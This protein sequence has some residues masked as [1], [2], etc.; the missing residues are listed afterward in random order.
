[1]KTVSFIVLFFA[2]L[3]NAAV[4]AQSNS[5]ATNCAQETSIAKQAQ[6][7]GD[8]AK[9]NL[10]LDPR[11]EAWTVD[12]LSYL[13]R[14]LSHL[15]NGDRV[16]AMVELNEAIK[17][18][19]QIAEAYFTRGSIYAE[20]KDYDRALQDFDQAI[21]LN[22][23][24]TEAFHQRALAHRGKL[25]FS[26]ALKDLNTA[27]GMEPFNPSLLRERGEAHLA[28]GDYDRAVD[29]YQDAMSIDRSSIDPYSM[30]NLLFFQGRFSQ[31]AQT[32]QQ[33]LKIKPENPYAMLWRYLAFAKANGV[34]AAARELADHSTR[35]NDKRWPTAAIDYYLGKIDE[36]ALRG[37]A[38]SSEALKNSEQI[39]Q[40]NFFAGEAK[41]LKGVH[42][43][44]IG[45]LRAAQSQCRPDSTFF[46]GASAELKRLGAL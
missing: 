34:A 35:S 33:V 17:L 21:S 40:A 41:L 7:T 43:E 29:D 4:T 6:P 9:A 18:N 32:M 11:S 14:A 2:L 23:V 26:Q 45:L 44:A 24:L 36:G 8:C 28:L 27:I 13:Q 25:E 39:C 22:P 19:S 3:T 15:K 20:D 42:E 5:A 37:A 31:S 16:A 30:A 1:M 12:A 10:Q 38:Q 46:H